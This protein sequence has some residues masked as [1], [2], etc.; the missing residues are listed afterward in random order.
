MV[1][2][3]SRIMSNHILALLKT[4]LLMGYLVCLEQQSEQWCQALLN[5]LYGLVGTHELDCWSYS[6]NRD[7]AP[8]VYE[9]LRRGKPVTVQDLRRHPHDRERLLKAKVLMVRR[10]K[11]EILTPS[12]DFV[13]RID[14][15]VL[16]CGRRRS[17]WWM[18]WI[19]NNENV[20]HYVLTG[21][22]GGGGYLWRNYLRQPKSSDRAG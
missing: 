21:N 10:D 17:A 7:V 18:G 16:L 14:D 13:L 20:M 2:S 8:A 3:P 12:D 9:Q 22:E 15:N 1:M 6:I 5:E 11:H 4:P 19:L